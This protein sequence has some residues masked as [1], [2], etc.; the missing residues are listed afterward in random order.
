[1]PQLAMMFLPLPKD[2]SNPEGT[3]YQLSTGSEAHYNVI[4]QD[5]C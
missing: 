4:S 3:A 2:Q 5:S 1:M